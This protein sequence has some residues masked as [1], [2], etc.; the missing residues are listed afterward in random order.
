MLFVSIKR[1][2]IDPEKVNIG[3][4]IHSGVFHACFY[5]HF[6]NKC[7]SLLAHKPYAAS[8][9]CQCFIQILLRSFDLQSDSPLGL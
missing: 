5:Q 9:H 4:I 3:L 1:L 2:D 7:K 8:A 6:S